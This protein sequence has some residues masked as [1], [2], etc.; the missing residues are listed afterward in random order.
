METANIVFEHQF[1]KITLEQIID[2][3]RLRLNMAE[4]M[5][6]DISGTGGA[7]KAR[8][9]ASDFSHDELR[10]EL[11]SRVCELRSRLKDPTVIYADEIDFYVD[12]VGDQIDD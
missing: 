7:L 8:G 9:L 2:L 1:D 6:Q 11:M 3:R 5:L 4:R 12:L 10:Q